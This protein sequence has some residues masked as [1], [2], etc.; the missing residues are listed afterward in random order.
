MRA[1]NLAWR[2]ARG[3]ASR[4]RSSVACGS[5]WPHGPRSTTLGS[6]LNEIPR[7]LTLPEPG[8]TTARRTLGRFL[9]QTLGDLMTLPPGRF[10]SPVFDG[11]SDVRAVI[12]R[13]LRERETGAVFSMLRRPT[14]SGLVRCLHRE[15]W[16]E[17]DVKK[18]DGWLTELT[19]L[20]ALELA[21]AGTLPPDGL[22]LTERPARLL[23]LALRVELGLDPRWRIGVR[24]GRLVLEGDGRTVELDLD[25]LDVTRG[26]PEGVTLTRP[27]HQIE[28]DLLLAERDNNPLA[29]FEA[30]PDK[31]GN[32]IDLAGR[33]VSDWVGALAASLQLVEGHLP[34][35]AD[36]IRLVMQTVVPVGYF[37]DRHLSASYAE[38]VGTAYLSLHPDPMTM[39][40][41]LVHEFSHNKL[42]A[43]WL[44]DPLL[45]NGFSPLFTSPVRPDPRP[46]HG[47]L[48]A[49]HAFVPVA[50]LYERLLETGHELSRTPSF[51]AR[52]RKIVAGNHDGLATLLENGVPT[53]VGRGVLAELERWDRH[54]IARFS[55]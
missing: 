37:A 1:S 6:A 19:A 30:H 16:G 27:Y 10:H 24:P 35:L 9:R 12:E 20:L 52:L 46:L 41:A 38:V 7:D 53:A 44:S 36:E 43:L 42:N 13:L 2:A 34:E 11:F 39:T 23:S 48:L 54:F 22:R 18:L 51:A 14:H 33:D 5:R 45:E 26:L 15:L 49:V 28:R 55:S 25:G 21:R 40:E 4:A 8:S 47:I 31:S 32:T 50:R 3:Q 17:G 29:E